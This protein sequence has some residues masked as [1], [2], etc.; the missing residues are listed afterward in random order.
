[1]TRYDLASSHRFWTIGAH[2]GGAVARVS[3][4]QVFIFIS[5]STV[6]SYLYTSYHSNSHAFNGLSSCAA[7]AT[8]VWRFFM[9]SWIADG[10]G[11]EY[12]DHDI[13]HICTAPSYNKQQ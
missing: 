6:A 10:A 4:L 12:L 1:M 9:G 3:K 13:H 5:T 7:R 8:I 11:A 2:L